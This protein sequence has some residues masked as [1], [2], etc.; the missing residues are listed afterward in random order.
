MEEVI[1]NQYTEQLIH[2]CQCVVKK[3]K[4]S[5][6]APLRLDKRIIIIISLSQHVLIVITNLVWVKIRLYPHGNKITVCRVVTIILSIVC[7]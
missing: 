5:L 6:T 4:I 1:N 2:I 7:S 3:N